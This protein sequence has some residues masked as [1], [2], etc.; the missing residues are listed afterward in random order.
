MFSLLTKMLGLAKNA[1]LPNLKFRRLLVF[2][3]LQVKIS[4]VHLTSVL[5]FCQYCDRRFNFGK[6][7]YIY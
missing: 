4:R 5:A 3:T 2:N 1:F 6:L 7:A